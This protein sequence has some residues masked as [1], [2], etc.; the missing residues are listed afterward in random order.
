MIQVLGTYTSFVNVSMQS[1]EVSASFPGSFLLSARGRKRGYKGTR[2]QKYVEGS[3]ACLPSL[4]P[5]QKVY[6]F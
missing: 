6:C 1:V 2:L 3:G 5:Q 4:H